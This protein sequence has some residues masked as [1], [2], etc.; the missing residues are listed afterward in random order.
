MR[1]GQQQSQAARVKNRPAGHRHTRT[2][3]VAGA[4]ALALLCA[5]GVA[6]SATPDPPPDYNATTLTGNWGGLRDTLFNDGVDISFSAVGQSAYLASG[7]RH[8]GSF[9]DQVAAGLTLDMDKLIGWQG[10]SIVILGTNRNGNTLDSRAGLREFVQTPTLVGGGHR[11]RLNDAYLDQKLWNDRLDIKVGYL[12]AGPAG[13]GFMS[14]VGCDTMNLTFCYS[15]LAWSSIVDFADTI[16]PAQRLGAVVT[17][18]PTSNTYFKVGAIRNNPVGVAHPGMMELA[19]F[20]WDDEVN[21]LPGTWSIGGWKDTA[22]FNYNGIFGADDNPFVVTD[23]SSNG[24]M[25][26]SRGVY[27]MVSQQVTKNAAGGGLTFTGW[28][29]FPDQDTSALLGQTIALGAIYK[30]PFASR[31]D[32]SV[33]LFVGRNQLNTRY[34][35]GQRILLSEGLPVLGYGPLGGFYELSPADPTPQTGYQYTAELDYNATVFR[36]VTVSPNVQ[37]VADPGGISKNSNYAI[38]GVQLALAF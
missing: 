33:S 29:I 11:S 18:K 20:G 37:F 31:P 2:R 36:G 34:A 27:A 7:G 6:L 13:A 35:N 17:V 38:L 19:E 30:A 25:R 24:I 14:G 21:G 10:A 23:P 8:I 9:N 5:S 16:F 3:G 1:H 15:P 12:E 32:D 26:G 4:I 22:Q 28:A